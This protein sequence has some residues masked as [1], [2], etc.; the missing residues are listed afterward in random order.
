MYLAADGQSMQ[1]NNKLLSFMMLLAGKSDI[2]VLDRIQTYH[3]W[4]AQNPTKM[5][6][7]GTRWIYSGF[8]PY[9]SVRLL[10]SEAP[11]RP[12]S[13]SL[14]LAAALHGT[15]GLVLQELI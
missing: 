7:R 11:A 14:G 5:K 13:T 12:W 3:F 2:V 10:K 4:D 1:L 6:E 15:R 9:P 8:R